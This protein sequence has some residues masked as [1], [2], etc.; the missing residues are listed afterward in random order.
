M[1]YIEL[2]IITEWEL[3]VYDVRTFKDMGEALILQSYTEKRRRWRPD[4]TP[5]AKIK[6]DLRG[7][8]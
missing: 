8:L 6:K 7:E 1:Y 3:I 4:K 5:P 2:E